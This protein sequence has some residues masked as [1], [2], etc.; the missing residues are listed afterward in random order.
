MKSQLGASLTD[1]ISNVLSQG[2]TNLQSLA[3]CLDH[4]GVASD[5]A[6]SQ[7]TWKVV[8]GCTM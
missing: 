4:R 8:L 3:K 1:S 5:T 7:A 2:Y 6:C